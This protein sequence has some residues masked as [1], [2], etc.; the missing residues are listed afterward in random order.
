MSSASSRRDVRR[1]EN[2]KPT[3]SRADLDRQAGALAAR[4][5]SD[6]NLSDVPEMLNWDEAERARFY[7]PAKQAITNRLD[8]DVLAWFKA[9]ARGDRYQTQINKVLRQYVTGRK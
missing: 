5:E 2:V 4:S 6:V 9:H 7:R 3:R 1:A 8:R